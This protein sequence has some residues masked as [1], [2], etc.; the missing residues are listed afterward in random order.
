[1]GLQ[2]F[3]EE[4]D[5]GSSELYICNTACIKIE[6]L[7]VWWE[8]KWRRGVPRP[9]WIRKVPQRTFLLKPKE[10][11]NMKK[12]DEWRGCSWYVAVRLPGQHPSVCLTPAGSALLQRFIR[13]RNGR[14]FCRPTLFVFGDYTKTFS[15]TEL[16]LFASCQHTHIFH[17][18][19]TTHPLG[20]RRKTKQF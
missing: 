5:N 6:T 1:M 3:M 14:G 13:D 11:G 18:T 7:H 15:K 12:A 17:S 20:Q 4:G 16:I 2:R 8:R 9:G 19:P 10:W